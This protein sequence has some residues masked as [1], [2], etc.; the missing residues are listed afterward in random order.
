MDA[1]RE[2]ITFIALL[3]TGGVIGSWLNE[4]RRSRRED[5][6]R[7]LASRREA[8][9]RLLTATHEWRDSEMEIAEY[10]GTMR[11]LTT[12]KSDPIFDEHW[13]VDQVEREGDLT[14]TFLGSRV[15]RLRTA[16]DEAKRETAASLSAIEMI[17]S[18][19]V[20]QCAT[21]VRNQLVSLIQVASEYPPRECGGWSEPLV[22][23]YDHHDNARRSF[24]EAVRKELGVHCFWQTN[25][26]S[27]SA[28]SLT[29]P[30]RHGSN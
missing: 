9:E 5:R 17:G 19:P 11:E 16:A 2:A 4:F 23:A 29:A 25:Q 27:C 3:G 13:F 28:A 12:W 22:T 18:P 30:V 21:V 10:I 24:V 6:L 20:V 14:V 26:G 7:W 15:R 1:L 8:Y